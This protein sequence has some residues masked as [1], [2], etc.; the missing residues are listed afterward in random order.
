[1]EEAIQAVSVAMGVTVLGFLWG[2][3]VGMARNL[4]ATPQTYSVVIVPPK[5]KAEAV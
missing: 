3:G 5:N 4:T 2:L 1:M